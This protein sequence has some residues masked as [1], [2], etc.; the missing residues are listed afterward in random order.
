LCLSAVFAV[1]PI[2]YSAYDYQGT[3]V[4]DSILAYTHNL[5][6]SPVSGRL[7][8]I[9]DK[10]IPNI[11]YA[12]SKG[13]NSKDFYVPVGSAL[14]LTDSSP[15]LAYDVMNFGGVDYIIGT[16]YGSQKTS[17]YGLSLQVSSTDYN[18][19]KVRRINV[20]NCFFFGVLVDPN[21]ATVSNTYNI[22]LVGHCFGNSINQNKGLAVSRA[23]IQFGSDL[24]IVWK[25]QDVYILEEKCYDIWTETT[26]PTLHINKENNVEFLYVTIP[27]KCSAV[28]RLQLSDTSPFNP[29][30]TGYFIPNEPDLQD[31]KFISSVVN[32]DK[33][34]YLTAKKYNSDMSYLIALNPS[35]MQRTDTLVLQAN[36]STPVLALDSVK[37]IVYIATAGFDKIYKFSNLKSVGVAVLPL[38]LKSV[39]SMYYVNGTIYIVTYEPNAEI[40]RISE[41]NFCPTYC[42]MHGYCNAGTCTCLKDYD[43]D[44]IRQEFVC[45][46]THYVQNE[47]IVQSEQGAAAAFGVLFVISIIAGVL[48]WFLWFRGSQG[49][50][51]I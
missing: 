7:W 12:M 45:A 35:S 31:V 32:A 2:S 21:T 39:S 18:D 33:R 11:Y 28:Y 1:D 24:P 14:N 51:S 36:E 42:S 41:L 3:Q 19:R 15:Y 10:G 23:T 30:R 26:K 5:K 27:G 40:G 17:N 46:P 6:Y 20:N 44:P 9:A 4:I 48:G 43:R 29:I 47:Y 34:I 16:T 25:E 37:D 8:F 38:S 13:P 22:Y 49:F 50:S